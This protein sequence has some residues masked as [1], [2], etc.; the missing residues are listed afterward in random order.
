MRN[1]EVIPLCRCT[2][3]VLVWTHQFSFHLELDI[4]KYISN[5]LSNPMQSTS[6]Q[7][8]C[9]HGR[10]TYMHQGELFGCDACSARYWDEMEGDE[11][12]VEYDDEAEYEAWRDRMEWEFER[13]LEDAVEEHLNAYEWEGAYQVVMQELGDRYSMLVFRS[14]VI[15]QLIEIANHPARMSKH[16]SHYDDFEV[17]LENW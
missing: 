14:R 17:A 8:S 11:D 15:P 7:S 4:I 6:N 2:Y 12:E 3:D 16:I 1:K 5:Q 9:E 13:S 10:T